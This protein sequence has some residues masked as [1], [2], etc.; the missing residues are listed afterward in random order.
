MDQPKQY[1]IVGGDDDTWGSR[2]GPVIA[3][4]VGEIELVGFS[5]YRLVLL[6][7]LKPFLVDGENVEFLVVSPRYSGFTLND[8]RER[9]CF[10]AIS[11]I[12]PGKQIDMQKGL[13]KGDIAS[14]S[15]GVCKPVP[16]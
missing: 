11:R 2:F 7:L 3:E 8:I 1:E 5:G 13:S 16:S 14:L 12:L 15:I 10:V 4:E 6:H 9:G